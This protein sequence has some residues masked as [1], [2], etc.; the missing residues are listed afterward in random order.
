MRFKSATAA[1]AFTSSRIVCV[2]T[3][4]ECVVAWSSDCGRG[5]GSVRPGVSWA[6]KA[7][8]RMCG[9]SWPDVQAACKAS[10][11][12]LES[13]ALSQL[14][15]RD[16]RQDRRYTVEIHP[17]DGLGRD[18][19]LC[20]RV[21]SGCERDDGRII[22]VIF[23]VEKH[24][25]SLAGF[26]RVPRCSRRD[27]VSW[28]VSVFVCHYED[29]HV[30]AVTALLRAEKTGNNLTSLVAQMTLD[31]KPRMRDESSV[32]FPEP[33]DPVAGLTACEVN[34]G[35]T[36]CRHPPNRHHLGE[37]CFGFLLHVETWLGRGTASGLT[38]AAG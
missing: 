28:V 32:V 6:A 37:W 13:R 23:E 15:L 34:S 17:A 25:G 38:H 12:R 31:E 24:A 19:V 22:L 9:P 7:A 5:A 3:G 27:R 14:R 26:S 29:R 33:S 4:L 30:L 36:P 8:G 35:P 16:G 18:S 10:E 20:G 2:R 1:F 11:S 21:G